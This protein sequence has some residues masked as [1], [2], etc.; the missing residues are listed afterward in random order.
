MHFK[1]I[2]FWGFKLTAILVVYKA[3][4]L[5][6]AFALFASSTSRK[7]LSGRPFIWFCRATHSALCPSER[8]DNFWANHDLNNLSQS[9]RI[10]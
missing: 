5:P 2:H 1:Q 8:K 4:E 3:N 10:Q 6:P 7:V 9:H